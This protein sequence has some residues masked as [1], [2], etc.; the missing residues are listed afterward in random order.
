VVK[1]E[2]RVVG[3]SAVVEI[4]A[5]ERKEASVR[6]ER[7]GRQVEVVVEDVETREN[8]VTRTLRVELP[9][10]YEDLGL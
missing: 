7:Y 5:G 9:A 8:L 10:G 6:L 1:L 3:E 2:G 4:Q